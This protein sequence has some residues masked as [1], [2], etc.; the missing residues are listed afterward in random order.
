ME[1]QSN[2]ATQIKDQDLNN[3]TQLTT[4]T[5][6]AIESLL[7]A[8][9]DLAKKKP[10]LSLTQKYFEFAKIGE[11]TRGIFY[12]LTTITVKDKESED[13]RE[14]KA[15]QWISNKQVYINGGANLVS[16][17]EKLNLPKGAAIEI[18]YTEKSGQVKIYSISLLG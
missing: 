5:T 12:G 17:L 9:T 10:S 2:E 18:E 8:S 6:D 3:E 13:L 1:T 14:I 4:I 16:Q 7:E 11:K 15:A